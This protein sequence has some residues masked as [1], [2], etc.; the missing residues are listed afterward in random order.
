MVACGVNPA[1][2]AGIFLT[3]EHGDH[4]RGLRVFL[5]KFPTAVYATP[6]TQQVVREKGNFG[7]KWFSFEAGQKFSIGEL[8]VEP[9]AIQHDAVDPVGFVYGWSGLR[10]GIVSDAGYVTRSMVEHLRGVHGLFV[11]A[12]YDDELLERD[13]KRPFATKQ[14]IRSRHGH[15]SNAQM[16]EFVSEVA[17]GDL[18]RVVLGHLSRD[19]NQPERAMRMLREKLG[20]TSAM[21]VEVVCAGDEVSPWW[22]W[23]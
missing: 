23:G 15:L 17:S 7:G 1:E 4:V 5:K 18:R 19:C 13:L 9:F 16:V 2:L 21:E 3:H 10:V 14:R 22:H 20:Q 6:S 11:E 8:E 12:N